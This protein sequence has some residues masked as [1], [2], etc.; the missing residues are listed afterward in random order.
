M[1]KFIRLSLSVLLF[2]NGFVIKSLAQM[3]PL[4]RYNN[5]VDHLYQ[6]SGDENE[7][8]KYGYKPEGKEGYVYTTQVAGTVP[9]Y[10]YAN[11]KDHMYQLDPKKYG[12]PEAFGYHAEGI[13]CYVYPTDGPSRVPLYRYYNGVDHLYQIDKTRYGGPE[14]YG[15]HY[16]GI[17]GYVLQNRSDTRTNNTGGFSD[18]YGGDIP[19]DKTNF[20]LHCRYRVLNANQIELELVCNGGFAFEV[21][22]KI[23]SNTADEGNGWQ[24]VSLSRGKSTFV[25]ITETAQNCQNGFWWWFRNTRSTMVKI[26]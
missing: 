19:F 12:G 1:V 2:L 13:C 10:R 7:L 17:E 15:Y 4:L 23:C 6:T 25:T 16:E 18:W 26:D 20:R 22:S 11:D 3:V 5:G 9:L 21:T 24:K 8:L 14:A